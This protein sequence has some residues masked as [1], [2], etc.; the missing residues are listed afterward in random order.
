MSSR[1]ASRLTPLFLLEEASTPAGVPAEAEA[2]REGAAEPEEGRRLAVAELADES[3]RD[4][5]FSFLEV[6][7]ALLASKGRSR[8]FGPA[9]A[10]CIQDLV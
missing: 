5:L 8:C 7:A 10:F 3:A 4:T 2:A 6:E 9:A 1:L